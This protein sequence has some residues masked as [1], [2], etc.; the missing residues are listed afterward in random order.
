[1]SGNDSSKKKKKAIQHLV[2][3]TGEVLGCYRR[4]DAGPV[5][6]FPVSST[7]GESLE[8][9]LYDLYET[10]SKARPKMHRV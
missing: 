1:M 7:E 8:L 10:D 2:F 9:S 3:F 4:H 5:G 6:Y